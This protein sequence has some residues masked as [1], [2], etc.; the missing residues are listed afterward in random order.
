MNFSNL[1]LPAGVGVV[2]VA[3]VAWLVSHYLSA[4]ARCERRRRRSN[5]R[6]SSTAKRPMVRFSVNVSKARN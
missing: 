4:S 5:S 2:V 3:S 6:V 1:I